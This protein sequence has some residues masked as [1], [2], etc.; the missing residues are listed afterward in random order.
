MYWKD[1]TVGFKKYYGF[2]IVAVI[3]VMFLTKFNAVMGD[4]KSES[5]KILTM[6]NDNAANEL[7][8]N[9]ISDVELTHISTQNEGLSMINSSKN[10]D[11]FVLYQ[12]ENNL[13]TVIINP[14]SS[15]S[16]DLKFIFENLKTSTEYSLK[17][18]D[19]QIIATVENEKLR[20]IFNS[21][22]FIL[23]LVCLFV[24]YKML[25]DEKNTLTSIVFSPVKNSNILASKI[26]Y[27]CVLYL[28]GCLYFMASFDLS[29]KI[30][31]VLF[32][33]GPIYCVFGLLPGIFCKS[34]YISYLFYPLSFVVMM[35][36]MIIGKMLDY[37]NIIDSLNNNNVTLICTMLFELLLFVVLYY[38]LNYVFTLKLR[39]ERIC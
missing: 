8:I 14:Q 13:L 5:M 16:Q 35:L 15:K 10:L 2:L 4:D 24:P 25:V 28:I 11:A 19:K 20:N 37:K 21:F 23:T 33:L 39:R 34:K 9:A 26:M 31:A 7:L 18:L 12:K 27:T 1:L 29:I 38:G 22:S 3:M 36:P 17:V 30:I 32:L 6:T